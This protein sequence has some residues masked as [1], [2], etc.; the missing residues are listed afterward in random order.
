MSGQPPDPAQLLRDWIVIWQSEAAALAA[1]R[2]V[3]EFW[4][5]QADQWAH[6]AASWLPPSW[7]HAHDGSAGRAGPAAPAGA[8]AADAASGDRERDGRELARLRER[9]AELEARL[10]ALDGKS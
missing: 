1:D 7:A 9:V 4:Q 8:A 2:E 10:A 5:R 3:G 6:L